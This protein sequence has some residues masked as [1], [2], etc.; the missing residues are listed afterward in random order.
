[1]PNQSLTI[2]VSGKNDRILLG[3]FLKLASE[4]LHILR[5][6]DREGAGGTTRGLDWR[7]ETISRKSPLRL[8]I[9]GESRDEDVV[10]VD[11]VRLFVGAMN[12]MSKEPTWPE[13]FPR[14]GL[15]KLKDIVDLAHD[16]LGKVVFSDGK[17]KVEATQ[18]LGANIEF[19]FDEHTEWTTIDGRLEAVSAHRNKVFRI[20][21][22]LTGASVACRF[23]KEQQE[24][25]RQALYRR[26]SVTGEATYKAGM[27]HVIKVDS[28]DI[29]ENKGVAYDDLPPID[30][31][32]G[33][34]SVEH[35]RR[36]RD[37]E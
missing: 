13:G 3:S 2:T 12:T 7:I 30:I 17:T 10:A 21:D 33:V 28:I 14:D 4:T 29:I 27:P 6:I 8:T 19:L 20:Y 36:V 16:G 32:G 25:V 34:S 1:M 35:I 5:L 22:R 24:E 23:T 11:V 9:S 18:H 26:V 31:T 15:D 37:G